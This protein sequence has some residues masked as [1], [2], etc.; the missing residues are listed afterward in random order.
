MSF[1]SNFYKPA[2]KL[3]DDDYQKDS[4][5]F[6]AKTTQGPVSFDFGLKQE[7]KEDKKLSGELKWTESTKVKDVK[8]KLSGSLNSGSDV[9]GALDTDFGHGFSSTL[10]GGLIAADK[11]KNSLEGEAKYSHE[12][13][14]A[15]LG[16]KY[17]EKKLD[18]TGSA[19]TSY[20][21][22]TVGGSFKVTK[23]LDESK[24]EET[25]KKEWNAGVGYTYEDTQAL[26]NLSKSFNV[27]QFALLQK[28][29]KN[30][31]FGFQYTHDYS[32]SSKN[33]FSFGSNLKVD[34]DQ[35]LKFKVNQDKKVSVAYLV[36]LSKNLK[37][38]V[39]LNTTDATVLQNVNVGLT[40]NQ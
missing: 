40:Y 38:N 26:A 30:V 3:F 24:K 27:Y 14:N 6:N 4:F 39:T 17:A 22:F 16:G 7:K 32:D 35:T 11:A 34:E 33:D 1:F 5:S 13:V 18:V 2:S 9:K 29:N 23:N 21:S 36:N 31:E 19:L 10:K 28:V 25:M 37:A 15:T 8:V 12:F 20:E